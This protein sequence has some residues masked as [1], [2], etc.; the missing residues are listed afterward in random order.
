MHLSN[1]PPI[2]LKDS[3]AGTAA[4]KNIIA[5]LAFQMKFSLDLKHTVQSYQQ[6]CIIHY[7]I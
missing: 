1:F 6:K 5:L 2:K 3:V 4:G 7:G